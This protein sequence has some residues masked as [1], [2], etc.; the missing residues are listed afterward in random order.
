MEIKKYLLAAGVV[1]SLTTCKVPKKMPPEKEVVSSR[2]NISIRDKLHIRRFKYIKPPGRKL[3]LLHK[4]LLTEN[5]MLKKPLHIKF[6]KYPKLEMDTS[7]KPA[8]AEFYNY[9][10]GK[11]SL[12]DYEWLSRY[13]DKEIVKKYWRKPVE[14]L[15]WLTLKKAMFMLKS[16]SRKEY[17]LKVIRDFDRRIAF[18][19]REYESGNIVHMNLR[20]FHMLNKGVFKAINF[21][22]E[23]LKSKSPLIYRLT[24]T[25]K[26]RDFFS[27]AIITQGFTEILGFPYDFEQTVEYTNFVLEN[28]G[29]DFV[30]SWPATWDRVIS[31]G[32][33]QK[34]SHEIRDLGD[35]DKGCSNRM[36]DKFK[37]WGVIKGKI[38]M[39]TSVILVHHAGHFVSTT[40]TYMYYLHR[41]DL[42]FRKNP[43][44][45]AYR[46]L[47][48]NLENYNT[49]KDLAVYMALG[50]YMTTSA[51][52]LFREYIKDVYKGNTQWG[53]FVDWL[54]SNPKRVSRKSGVSLK[55]IRMLSGYGKKYEWFWTRTYEL[56]N[57]W[58]GVIWDQ[59]LKLDEKPEI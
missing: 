30:E 57:K 16:G 42:M 50:N 14:A 21:D 54:R 44:H 58:D 31:M 48:E 45:P 9:L 1:A 47:L 13:S 2:D 59:K 15:K 3:K 33:N 24:K 40:T 36:F 56:V 6:K 46:N 26:W 7:D 23:P 52:R 28:L 41:I 35:K 51:A 20:R 38:Y 27:S 12:K 49:R 34:T 5:I 11:K 17:V 22:P 25:R 4:K 39:P 55:H 32:W 37:E 43:N 10:N 19:K 53:D 8:E 18:Y 29:L